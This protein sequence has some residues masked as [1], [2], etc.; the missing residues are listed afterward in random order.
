MSL[1][2]Y[3]PAFTLSDAALQKQN[4]MLLWDYQDA[5][6]SHY[7]LLTEGENCDDCNHLAGRIFSISEARV[8][9]N[10]AP[11]HSNC[12]CRV[13]ILDDAGQVAYI[14]DEGKAEKEERHKGWFYCVWYKALLCR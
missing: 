3:I 9:E 14:I 8:G 10:F 2:L 7:C 12:N 6:F 1:F 5:G 11:M 13:G 4:Y